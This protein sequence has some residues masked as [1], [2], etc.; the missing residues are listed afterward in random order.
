M[1]IEFYNDDLLLTICESGDLEQFMW[2]FSTFKKNLIDILYF[3]Y[4]Y[5]E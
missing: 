2:L 4:Q 1:D 5:G 3:H